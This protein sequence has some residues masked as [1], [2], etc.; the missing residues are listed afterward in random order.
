M[1]EMTNDSIILF[2]GVCNLCNGFVQFIIARDNRN[3]FTFGSLQ[4][5]Q[6][7]HM[8]APFN[9]EREKLSTVFLIQNGTLYSQS[10]A[11]LRILKELDGFWGLMY[12]FIIVPPFFR[13]AVY[14]VLAKY[15]YNL[16]GKR[17]SCMVPTPELKN[18]FIDSQV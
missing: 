10:T 17:E 13:D 7:R 3:V 4:S 8:L 15:R 6:G 12:G 2:D 9:C 1:I 5:A 14:A 16:F 18:R 11:L